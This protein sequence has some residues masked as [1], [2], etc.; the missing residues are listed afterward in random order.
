MNYNEFVVKADDLG[1]FPDNWAGALDL[2]VDH[3]DYCDLPQNPGREC[4]CN[5]T[6]Y[7]IVD[8]K[9]VDLLIDGELAP[10]MLLAYKL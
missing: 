6:I 2:Y 5:P 8:G 3:D 1:F 4:T 9:R 10:T 7:M